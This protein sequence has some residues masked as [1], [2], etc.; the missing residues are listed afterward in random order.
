[1][2]EAGIWWLLAGAAIAVELVTGTFYLLMLAAGLVTGALA[3]S[4]GMALAGQMLMA[5]AIGGGAVAAWRWGRRQGHA[6]LEASSNPNV[7]LDI[8]DTVHV[9]LWNTDG[10]AGVHFR[11]ARWTAIAADPGEPS[12]PG[13]F[14]IKEMRG[15]RLVIEPL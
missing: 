7:H 9:V 10:T 8:G 5:A 6:P 12:V 13:N 2:G 14:R 3:A 11:G 4:L 15:N 1:M